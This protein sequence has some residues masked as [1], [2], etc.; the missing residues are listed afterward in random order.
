MGWS[1]VEGEGGP[2]TRLRGMRISSV[3]PKGAFPVGSVF[4]PLRAFACA[5][6]GRELQQAALLRA[7]A[8]PEDWLVRMFFTVGVARCVALIRSLCTSL[9]VWKC[10]QPAWEN[11]L[12]HYDELVVPSL[13]H[14]GGW[15]GSIVP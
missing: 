2:W 14:F 12:L 3:G 8:I 11:Q 10:L 9:D 4:Q 15:L 5:L 13:R 7:E 6:R 1:R